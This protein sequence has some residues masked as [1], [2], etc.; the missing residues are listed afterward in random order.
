MAIDVSA[1]TQVCC[2]VDKVAAYAFDPAHDPVW[3]TGIK[4][5]SLLTPAPVRKG[6]QVKRRAKFLG[7]SIDYILEV[8]NFEPGHLMEMK[9]VKSPFPMVVT[10]QFD[11]TANATTIAQIRV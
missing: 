9:S 3:I 11:A 5:A 6:T 10:Y 1:K 4:E 7:K 8:V 2:S